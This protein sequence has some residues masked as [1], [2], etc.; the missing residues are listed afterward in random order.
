MRFSSGIARHIVLLLLSV[1][2]VTTTA[3]TA[4]GSA[5]SY[6]SFS[7]AEVYSLLSGLYQSNELV[8][9]E[10]IARQVIEENPAGARFL[11]ITVPV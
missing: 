8:A 2:A 10:K 5:S 6:A 7:S 1:A 11:F 4:A 3:T 9:V